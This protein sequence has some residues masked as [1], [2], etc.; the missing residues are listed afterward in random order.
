MNDTKLENQSKET[1][2]NHS[3]AFYRDY[4]LELFKSKI[5][6]AFDLAVCGDA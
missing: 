5:Y 4:T 3:M 6:V 1:G 2:K